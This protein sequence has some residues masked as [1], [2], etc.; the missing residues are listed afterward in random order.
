MRSSRKK[1][2]FEIVARKVLRLK[3]LKSPETRAAAKQWINRLIKTFG[4]RR[5]HR[6]TDEHW[7]DYIESERKRRERKFYDDRKYMRM[8][9]RYAEKK[10]LVSSRLELQIPDLPWDAGREITSRELRRLERAA[11]GKLRF[12]ITIG[13]KMGLRLREMLGLRQDQVDLKN[14]VVRL[15]ARDT[16]TRR[17]RDVPIPTDLVPEFSRRMATSGALLFPGRFDPSKPQKN[18]RK[19]W[20]RCKAKARV[21]ARWH[22]LRHTCATIMLRRKVREKT[23]CEYLGMSRKVLDRIYSH[24]SLNDLRA[25]ARVMSRRARPGTM[26][27]WKKKNSLESPLSSKVQST[28]CTALLNP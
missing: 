25:A 26:E 10:H 4:E 20:E 7:I 24:L 23:V 22:D 3:K 16:K 1:P 9:L 2:T 17:S 13:W 15:R 11:S 19:A 27:A 5:I 28:A 21:K 12:Q 6:I 14:E 8:V 18:N